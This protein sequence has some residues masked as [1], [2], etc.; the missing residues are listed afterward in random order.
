MLL[1]TIL[2][3]EL[4][5]VVMMGEVVF[6]EELVE[7]LPQIVDFTVFPLMFRNLDAVQKFNCRNLS[8]RSLKDFSFVEHFIER[9][10]FIPEIRDWQ[11]LKIVHESEVSELVLF[12]GQIGKCQEIILRN[13]EFLQ[14][15][16]TQVQLLKL[17]HFL[18]Q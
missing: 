12:K 6:P 11:F 1:L 9:V 5:I 8:D 14:L 2:R 18:A 16:E 10:V 17:G 7:S 4:E 13:E 15:V 3:E